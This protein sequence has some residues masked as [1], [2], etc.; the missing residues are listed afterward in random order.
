MHD[1]ILCA[2]V[3]VF[4]IFLVFQFASRENSV[5]CSRG[6]KRLI[7]KRIVGC[8]LQ[9]ALLTTRFNNCSY[10]HCPVRCG[11]GFFPEAILRQ[12]PRC[13]AKCGK[14]N[15]VRML[16]HPNSEPTFCKLHRFDI[17]YW[18]FFWLN[19][20]GSLSL[21]MLTDFKFILLNVFYKSFSLSLCCIKT[22]FNFLMVVF[23]CPPCSRT[24][25]FEMNFKWECSAMLSLLFSNGVFG[26]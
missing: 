9:Y 19:A 18:L 25:F 2:V 17:W 7:W 8:E 3:V 12:R 14:K 4:A 11:I 6:F 5:V 21:V 13:W 26:N 10:L 22:A 15:V 20:R 16:T 24:S 1:V 23:D